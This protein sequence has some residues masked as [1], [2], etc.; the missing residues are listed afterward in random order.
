[1]DE[2]K[3]SIEKDIQARMAE[4][5]HEREARLKSLICRVERGEESAKEVKRRL[6][7]VLE[8]VNAQKSGLYDALSDNNAKVIYL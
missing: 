2:I 1:M 3:D 6:S 5:I 4:L 8:E 7:K